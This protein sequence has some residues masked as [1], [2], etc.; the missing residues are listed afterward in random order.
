MSV[1]GVKPSFLNTNRIK[2]ISQNQLYLKIANFQLTQNIS[3]I[4]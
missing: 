3:I 1:G 2:Y 4:N